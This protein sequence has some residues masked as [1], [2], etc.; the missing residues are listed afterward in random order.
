MLT[1]AL[2]AEL[3]VICQTRLSQIVVRQKIS[4]VQPLVAELPVSYQ[5]AKYHLVM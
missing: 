1:A 4:L 5:T 2:P 3:Q